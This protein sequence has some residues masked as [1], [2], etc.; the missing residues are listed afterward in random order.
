MIVLRFNCRL[1]FIN[2]FF[3]PFVPPICV[4]PPI[5]AIEQ[6]HRSTKKNVGNEKMIDRNSRMACDLHAHRLL[7]Y[8][9]LLDNELTPAVVKTIVGSFVFLT[10]RHTWNKAAR[11]LGKLLVPETELYELLTVTRRR[12]IGWARKQKQLALDDMLQVRGEPLDRTTIVFGVFKGVLSYTKS[13]ANTS[14]KRLCRS[15]FF[16]QFAA[17]RRGI[18]VFSIGINY[19]HQTSLRAL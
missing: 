1:S 9:N 18:S 19:R 15:S 11:K 17:Y 10:T 6:L 16:L 13:C 8:R 12:I 14:R 7:L 4:F 5:Y 3:N 2:S